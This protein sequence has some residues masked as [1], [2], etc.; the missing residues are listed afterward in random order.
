LGINHFPVG[1][2]G[3]EIEAR[4]I[5]AASPS[6]CSYSAYEESCPFPQF[7]K[8]EGSGSTTSAASFACVKPDQDDHDKEASNP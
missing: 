4:D 1:I 8:Y 7:A 6:C 3:V 5:D 2:Q